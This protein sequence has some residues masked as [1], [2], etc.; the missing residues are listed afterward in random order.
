MKTIKEL[1]AEINEQISAIESELR[2]QIAQE[3]FPI[4]VDN[5]GRS[6]SVE[7]H[8]TYEIFDNDLVDKFLQE[9]DQF[10][11]E[12]LRGLQHTA[13]HSIQET[14][15]ENEEARRLVSSGSEIVK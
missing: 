11:L 13:I 15:E 4:L 5:T 14:I 2:K 3:T 9:T 8:V 6:L 12:E 1:K 10:P 7:E